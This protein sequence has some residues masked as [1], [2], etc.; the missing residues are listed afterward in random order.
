MYTP[1]MMATMHAMGSRKKWL[2]VV[3]LCRERRFGGD[4]EYIPGGRSDLDT[5]ARA[6]LDTS[7]LE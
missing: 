2:G 6:R 5:S 1:K 4:R 7:S 3:F